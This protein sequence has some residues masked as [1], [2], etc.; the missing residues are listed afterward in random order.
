METRTRA[1]AYLVTGVIA[2]LGGVLVTVLASGT[3]TGLPFHVPLMGWTLFG[4]PYLD[5]WFLQHYKA[6]GVFIAIGLC[7]GVG[8]GLHLVRLGL[9]HR[10]QAVEVL[11]LPTEWRPRGR[12]LLGLF[13]VLIGMFLLAGGIA[14]GMRYAPGGLFTGLGSLVALLGGALPYLQSLRRV[15]RPVVRCESIDGEAG[16]VVARSPRLHGVVALFALALALPGIA[17]LTQGLRDVHELGGLVTDETVPSLVFGGTLLLFAV[18]AAYSALSR[19]LH[20]DRLALTPTR[21]IHRTRRST[22]AVR[23]DDLHVPISAELQGNPQLALAVSKD[24][25]VSGAANK[26]WNRHLA[27]AEYRIVEMAFGLFAIDPVTLFHALFWYTFFPDTRPELATH[28]AVQRLRDADFRSS[29]TDAM[30]GRETP[31]DAARS[32]HET[33]S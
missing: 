19:M 25:P 1:V 24:C 21:L 4:D 22:V 12:I 2:I 30:E 20:R 15:R 3:A 9:Q 29:L 28:T 17:G 11:P 8:L 27:G 23:W 18:V 31:S 32:D 26:R 13:N 6:S 14:T 5:T 10:P 16:I 33:S 7:C